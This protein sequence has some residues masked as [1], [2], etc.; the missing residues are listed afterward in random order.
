[1][2]TLVKGLEV[3]CLT[4]EDAHGSWRHEDEQN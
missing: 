2:L 3:A 1:M 4:N